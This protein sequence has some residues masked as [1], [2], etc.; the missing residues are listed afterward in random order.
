MSYA[1]GC[2][3]SAV[4]TYRAARKAHDKKERA[5]LR[6]QTR[7]FTVAKVTHDGGNTF[8]LYKV[9]AGHLHHLK[10][11]FFYGEAQYLTAK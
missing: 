4:D 2:L 3:G 10:A 5:K 8:K 7:R 11:A 9:R 6:N 1:I